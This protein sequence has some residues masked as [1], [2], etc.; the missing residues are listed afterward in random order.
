MYWKY[1]L[2]VIC[3]RWFVF[4]A[5]CKARVPWRGLVHDL[6][7][8]RPSEFVPYARYFYGGEKT[9]EVERA[10]DAAWLLHQHRNAHH[11]QHWVLRKDDGGPKLLDM[12]LPYM[13]E[14]V[15]DWVGAGRAITGKFGGTR[16][17]YEKNEERILLSDLTS[18]WV[19]FELWL[20]EPY[21]SR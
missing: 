10:F 14:M 15:A 13:R 3:H 12:P 5:C 1:L 18:A 7:K 20:H 21:N 17:W 8:L 16:E 4:V 19:G 11:W 9:P 2:Y 6:S